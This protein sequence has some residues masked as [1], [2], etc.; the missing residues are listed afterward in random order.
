MVD[1]FPEQNGNAVLLVIQMGKGRKLCNYSGRLNTIELLKLFCELFNK[2]FA[3]GEAVQRLIR[4][5]A[6]TVLNR[7]AALKMGDEREITQECIKNGRQSKGFQLFLATAGSGIGDTYE[8]YVVYINSIFDELALDLGVLFDRFSPFSLLFPRENT[9]DMLFTELNTPNLAD[10]WK[11]DETIGWIYQY[12]NSKE[13]RQA[14]RK[15]SSAPRNSRELAVRNQFFTPRYVVQFLTD[16]TL[17]RIWYEMT[18]GDTELKEQCEY[19]VRRP[20]EVFLD[21]GENP[22]ETPEEEND[23]SQEE[24]LKEPEYIPYRKIKDPREIRMLDPACGSMHFGLYAFDFYET[25]YEEA[26]DRYPELLQDIREKVKERHE[27]LSLVLELIIRH[28]IHGIDIDHRAVQISGLSLWL[29][30]QKSYQRLGIHP[31]GRP[32][33]TRSN[34][35]CAEPMPGEKDYLEEFVSDLKPAVLGDLI[36]DVWDKMQLAGEAGSLLKIEEELSDSIRKAREAWEKYKFERGAYIEQDLFEKNKQLSLKEMIGFD[37]ADIE[38]LEEWDQME[39]MVLAALKEFAESASGNGGYNRK[40]F[41]EDAAGGFAFIDVCRKRY[42]VVL[43]NPPFGEFVKAHKAQARDNYPNSY[44]DIFAAFAERWYWRLAEVGALGA[45]TSRV[46]FFLT[47]FKR[48]R[49]EFLLRNRCLSILVDLGEAVMDEAM[50]ESAGYILRCKRTEKETIVVRLLGQEARGEKLCCAVD[51]ICK[52]NTPGSLFVTDLQSCTSL[53]NAPIVYWIDPDMVVA[54]G[55]HPHIEPTIGEVRCGLSTGDNFRFVRLLW[56]VASRDFQNRWVP[57]VMTGASQPWFSPLLVV[58]DWKNDGNYLA[59]YKGSTIRSREF[60]FRLGFSWTLR[61]VRFVPYAIP[62][63]CIPSPSGR[64]HYPQN[65]RQLL[66]AYLVHL[67][68]LQHQLYLPRVVRFHR[69]HHP[70]CRMK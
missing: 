3:A 59:E 15:S 56:E 22:P 13:E 4:E 19:L 45:I 12:F 17:G 9:L 11:E 57:L 23:K 42:D 33:I 68:K 66:P 37:V 50:V 32:R 29:R 53:P 69:S 6:F 47:T 39:A 35:V 31:E 14:M 8:R 70:Y 65:T 55:R 40:L 34:V 41:A 2:K 1:P 48:W 61:A 20:H 7:F 60:Y 26:W 38:S 51:K 10:I 63:G 28:N 52:G 25:I 36:R 16:N 27:F 18:R 44:N 21:E 49:S 30:A 54:L 5:Q 62:E 24:L 67:L 64:R 46:G 58:V 43:M